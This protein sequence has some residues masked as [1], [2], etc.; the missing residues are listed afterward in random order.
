MK[1][2]LVLLCGLLMAG[3]VSSY[4]TP[5]RDVWDSLLRGA[6]FGMMS[7]TAKEAKKPMFLDNGGTA[8]KQ[9]ESHLYMIQL[10]KELADTLR[11]PG[12]TVQRVGPD[13]LVVMI[14]DV[15]MDPNAPDFSD[16]GTEELQKLSAILKKQNKTFIE[17]TGYTDNLG[18]MDAN[19]AVSFDMAK[20]VAIFFAKHE[21]RPV[22][23]FVQGRGSTR[24]IA[25][26]ATE[27]GRRMNRR[28]EIRISPVL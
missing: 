15:F 2:V 25:D 18:Q 19:Q 9:G 16:Q 5:S 26:N 17:I 12:T 28:I 1:K 14:R 20:R 3:C 6:S 24:P 21:I 11:K 23:L 7:E 27:V 8:L 13:V 10:E 22:R 4:Q